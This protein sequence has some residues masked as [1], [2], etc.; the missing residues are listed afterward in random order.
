MGLEQIK[1]LRVRLSYFD[2]YFSYDNYALGAHAQQ[3][4]QYSVFVSVYRVL[5]LLKEFLYNF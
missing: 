3:G 5:Q 4:I 2:L 1:N